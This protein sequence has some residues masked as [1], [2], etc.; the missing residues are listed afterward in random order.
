[1][2][3]PAEFDIQYAWRWVLQENMLAKNSHR[4]DNPMRPQVSQLILNAIVPSLCYIRTV[5]FFDEALAQFV[6]DNQL[7]S[8]TYR[9]NL[10]GRLQLL[11]A[12][13]KIKN[14]EKMISIK[15]RRNHLAHRS[16]VPES[17]AQVSISWAD[18]DEVI[19][20]IE[21]ELQN[22]GLIDQRPNFNF[23]SDRRSDIYPEEFHPDKPG[24]RLTQHYTFGIKEDEQIVLEFR[25]SYDI[26]APGYKPPL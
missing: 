11:N 6:D 5:S 3:L 20:A 15:N 24:V 19:D 8:K 23:F 2:N 18:V 25:Q 12:R 9:N 21:A 10:D 17:Y 16:A 13:S 14:F 4:I 22:L 1:M 26:F 7:D